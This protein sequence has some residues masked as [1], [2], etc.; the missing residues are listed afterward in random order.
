MYEW[1][2]TK[3]KEQLVKRDCL[4]KKYLDKGMDVTPLMK[5]NFKK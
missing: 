5:I 4:M 1:I 3:E 2:A